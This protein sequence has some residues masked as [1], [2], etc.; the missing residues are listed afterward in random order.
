MISKEWFT[1]RS[2]YRISYL[3]STPHPS[4]GSCRPEY[5]RLISINDKAV[6]N[7]KSMDHDNYL[8][9]LLTKNLN[10]GHAWKE[11]G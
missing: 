9:L 10:S 4:W 2:K 1:P 11:Q 3:A 8:T 6:L 7:F 5:L